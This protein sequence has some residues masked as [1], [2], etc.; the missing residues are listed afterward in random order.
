MFASQTS[1]K[2]LEIPTKKAGIITPPQDA[3]VMKIDLG[4]GDSSKTSKHGL[5]MRT[6]KLGFFLCVYV[7]VKNENNKLFL[8]TVVSTVYVLCYSGRPP[9]TNGVAKRVLT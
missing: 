6:N 7:R 3:N 4:T 8:L 9:W 5:S 2:G 1:P